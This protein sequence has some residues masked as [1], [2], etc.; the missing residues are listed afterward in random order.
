MTVINT[1]IKALYTESA[2]KITQRDSLAATKEIATGKR[3][4]TSMDDPAGMAL[5]TRMTQNIKS[6]QQANLN[7]NNAISLIQIADDASG[8][9][10]NILQK[11]NELSMQAMNGTLP[12]EQRTNLDLEYQQ[13][14]QEIIRTAATTQSNGINILSGNVG[15]QVGMPTT[16]TETRDMALAG[17][18]VLGLSAT[19]LKIRNSDGEDIS[20][21]ASD[22]DDDT[23]SDE[24]C[25]S[26]KKA[27]SAIAI[28]AAINSAILDTGVTATPT[29]AVIEGAATS[30]GSSSINTYL[31]L[32]GEKVTMNLTEGQTEEERR[33]Y[34]MENINSGSDVHGVV[35]FDLGLGGLTLKTPDGRNLSVWYDTSAGVTAT[36]FGLGTTATPSEDVDGVTGL[37]NANANLTSGVPAR[38]LY[39]GIKLDSDTTFSLKSDTVTNFKAL[40]FTDAS[41]AAQNISR[42]TFQ[43]GSLPNQIVT[44][45]LPDFGK[46]G[47]I[48]G[49]VT[50]DTVETGIS[51]AALAQVAAKQITKSLNA[52][53]NARSNMGSVINRLQEVAD[54]L[55]SITTNE[56]S[57]RSQ[58]QDAD[59]A[60][61]STEVSRT[62]ILQQVATSILAQANADMQTVMKL[63]Q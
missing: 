50:S 21:P 20:I 2:M 22:E 1:N 58:I 8:S 48:T 32:N 45:D 6:L 63:L 61:A 12:S 52:V 24:T 7:A 17:A 42:I 34:V 46:E 31:Y 9:I 36:D 38:T 39:G 62:A 54:N 56:I 33:R 40:G 55:I 60:A 59:I 11:M 53:A 43:I 57:A 47:D 28:A 37:S 41:F 51:S 25:N 18:T 19:D 29:A 15:T 49:A 26:S 35:A 14:K 3:I 5:V 23:L 44:I 30:V 27:A 4:N 13:L 16:T 10:T